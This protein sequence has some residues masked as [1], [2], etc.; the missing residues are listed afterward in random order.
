[1][2]KKN[3]NL[4]PCIAVLGTGSDVGKSIVATALCRIFSRRGVRVA[5][6]KAQNMSN[7]S[8]VTPEGLEM[9]RAQIVQAEAARVPPHVD[10]NPILLKPTSEI[11]SQVVLLG[12][13]HGNSSAADYH[14]RKEHLFHVAAAALER[15]RQQFELIILEG[16]GSC[17][18][19]NLMAADIVN[20]RMAE[21][22][23]APV[24]L[25]ADIHR[26]GVFGQI[27]GT[28]ACLEPH[29][30]KLIQGVIV[31]RFRGDIALFAE[32]VRWIEERTGTRVF[33]V[34]PWFDHIRIES[35][36][37]VAI[38][39]PRPVVLPLAGGPA[40]L[41]V[42][43]FP[44]ISN[45]TDFEP[46]GGIQDLRIHFLEQPQRLNG[47]RAVVLPGSKNTRH[48][49]EWL[50]TSGW[51]EII[52]AYHSHGGHVLGICGGYQMLGRWVHDP[53]GHEGRSGSTEG[54]HLLPVETVLRAPKTTTLTRFSWADAQGSGYEIHMGQ[55]TRH[56]GAPLFTVLERNGQAASAED[57]CVDSD[58]RAMGTYMHGMFDSPPITARWLRAAG[59][60]TPQAMAL[61]GLAARDREYDMLADHVETHVD[62]EAIGALAERV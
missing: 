14:Q 35:E 57:G 33:G 10:M 48:D 46:L 38:E 13:A 43:R 29:Q 41:A 49:L 45:F 16:A 3:Q 58:A 19:V 51:A 15:L 44:H 37:S 36:D 18:E 12:T 5:P 8:G 59:F 62:V 22:A 40:A 9:G 17:A 39:N 20:L 24:V 52:R 53:E 6:F 11:G 34:L 50:K 25:V 61:G 55:T 27:V 4:A 56:G 23:G 31:N 30:R 28:L 26:G 1:M 32:G 60:D 42:I 2:N 47:F 54:L 21:H 7:N